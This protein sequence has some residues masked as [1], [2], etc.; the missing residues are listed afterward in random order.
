MW[1]IILFNWSWN[2]VERKEKE[3]VCVKQNFGTNSGEYELSKLIEYKS[4]S[5]IGQK[6]EWSGFSPH[7]RNKIQTKNIL[8]FVGSLKNFK[9]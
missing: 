8:F 2:N 7:E 3:R 1:V 9:N 5:W 4:I 6:K